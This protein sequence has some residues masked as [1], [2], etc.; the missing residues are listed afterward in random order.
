MSVTDIEEAADEIEYAFVLVPPK[1][2][3]PDSVVLE[4]ERSVETPLAGTGNSDCSIN[5]EDCSAPGGQVTKGMCRVHYKR[6]W[7]YGDV[8][9]HRPGGPSYHP[10]KNCGT[11]IASAAMRCW[12]CHLDFEREQAPIRRESRPVIPELEVVELEETPAAPPGQRKC[13]DCEADASGF[14]SYCCACKQ[15]RDACSR[16]RTRN[17]NFTPIE[18]LVADP[19]TLSEPVELVVSDDSA[20]YVYR[21]WNEA[22]D[23]LYVGQTTRVHPI[24][25]AIQ[26]KQQYWWP[27]VARADYVAV[28][29]PSRLEDAERY[30][31]VIL[32]PKYNVVHTGRLNQIAVAS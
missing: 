21:L 3:K 26:H 2:A 28:L 5:D 16:A 31:I 12:S 14:R 24:L 18:K 32:K 1:R 27:E 20:A 17:P 30:E 9:Y 19:P 15:Y 22:G 6:F 10:C 8:H 13:L 23:C 29:D 25:R 11:R 4:A 7:R